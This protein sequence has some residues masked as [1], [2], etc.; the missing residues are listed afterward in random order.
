MCFNHL[1]GKVSIY[2]ARIGSIPAHAP[3]VGSANP[4]CTVE[5]TKEKSEKMGKGREVARRTFVEGNVSNKPRSTTKPR[6]RKIQYI[7][8]TVVKTHG[9]RQQRSWSHHRRAECR[10]SPN[11]L[12]PLMSNDTLLYITHEGESKARKN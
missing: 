2:H 10:L 5:Y 3:Q 4:I 11:S 9:T 6:R 8:M 12:P 1:K 7:D